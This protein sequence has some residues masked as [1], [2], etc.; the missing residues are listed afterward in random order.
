MD[1]AGMAYMRARD[2]AE[3]AEMYANMHVLGLFMQA[4]AYDITMPELD[5]SSTG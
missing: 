5:D 4:N 1:G 3:M 2:A